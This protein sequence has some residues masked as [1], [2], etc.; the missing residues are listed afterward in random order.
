MKQLGKRQ[1]NY[2]ELVYIDMFD[3]WTRIRELKSGNGENKC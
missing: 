3:V 2:C 1:N